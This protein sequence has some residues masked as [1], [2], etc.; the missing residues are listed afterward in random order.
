MSGGSWNYMHSEW[1]NLGWAATFEDVAKRLAG[2]PAEPEARRI[3]AL[4]AE[5]ERRWESLDPVLHAM[6]WVD[7]GDSLPSDLVEA[8]E[9][10]QREA[11]QPTETT[12]EPKKR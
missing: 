2:T 8:I 4:F 10:W 5:A 1:R 11:A 3:A 9:Q 6:E 12:V 7:S